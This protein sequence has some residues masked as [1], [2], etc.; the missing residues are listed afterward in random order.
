[1]KSIL[2]AT[3]VLLGL[4]VNARLPGQTTIYV[5]GSSTNCP[6]NGTQSKPYCQI[7]SGIQAASKGDT[8]LVMP[9]IYNEAID[10]LGKAITVRGQ[11]GPRTTILDGQQKPVS[12]LTTK[13]IASDWLAMSGEI[14]P[15]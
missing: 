7:Q 10:F 4:S 1:M 8:V 3:L 13:S 5:D 2:P 6:G 11:G 14:C 12:K 15:P 9:G